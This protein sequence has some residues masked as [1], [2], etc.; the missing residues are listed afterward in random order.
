MIE[1]DGKVYRN[2]QEQIKKNMD[3]IEDLDERVEALEEA[4]GQTYTAGNGIDIDNNV[5]SVEPDIV[6]ENQLPTKVSDLTNDLDF[7]PGVIDNEDTNYGINYGLSN[8]TPQLVGGDDS[9]GHPCDAMV[10]VTYNQVHI[11]ANDYNHG[12]DDDT[13]TG[14]IDV[15]DGYV[16]I[17][18]TDGTDTTTLRVAPSGVTVNG[19][20]I[21]GGT[22]YTAG[23]GIDITNNEISVDNTVALKTD[24]PAE[25]SGTNDGT[26]WT[27][28]TIGNTTKAI[29][30][31]GSSTMS[32]YINRVV[33]YTTR[34]VLDANNYNW[35]MNVPLLLTNRCTDSATFGHPIIDLDTTAANNR[36]GIEG[37]FCMRDTANDVTTIFWT[38]TSN[39]PYWTEV[40]FRTLI[41]NRKENSTVN[42]EKC[43][44]RANTSITITNPSDQSTITCPAYRLEMTANPDL[45]L[46]TNG[47]SQL[48][49]LSVGN[50]DKNSN[51][52][53]IEDLPSV[54]GTYV[55]KATVNSSGICTGISW[56]KES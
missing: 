51:V 12:D 32:P 19:D 48:I 5:I 55:L 34:P 54:A 24:L 17:E 36:I 40:P 26:N 44:I 56:V 41:L 15:T 29:P 53:Y 31:G 23:T 21:G 3:D 1:I 42:V 20:P 39:N 9:G 16:D 11:N 28:L 14:S 13:Y 43:R 4:P 47:G 22:T 37:Y 38:S 25:V 50:F 8:N 10:R 49:S 6:R 52:T 33:S 46:S 30:Q 35:F 45:K 2:V 18:A 27:T 7:I